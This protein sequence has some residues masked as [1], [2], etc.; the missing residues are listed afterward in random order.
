MTRQRWT[1]RKRN[2]PWLFL[3]LLPVWVLP[4]AAACW[5]AVAMLN[6]VISMGQHTDSTLAALFLAGPT[7]FFWWLLRPLRP[8]AH[9]MF[10]INALNI[11]VLPYLIRLETAVVVILSVFAAIAILAATG[12]LRPKIVR[13][14][15]CSSCGHSLDGLRTDRCPECGR[16]QRAPAMRRASAG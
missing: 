16:L 4:W 12:V 7:L 13:P 3:L 5:I 8:V 11:A 15:G 1:A 2:R 9:G 14:S 10:A 6:T